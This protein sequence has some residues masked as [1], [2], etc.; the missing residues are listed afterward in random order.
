MVRKSDVPDAA[1][2]AALELAATVGWR[3]LSMRDIAE[4]SGVTLAQLHGVYPTK[5]AILK[6]FSARIDAAVL[7]GDSVDLAAESAK[8]RLFDA[9]MRRFDA[10]SAHKKAACSI[11]RALM[12]RPSSAL[13]GFC[14]TRTS[15]H[16]ML[17]V[18][19]ID[20]GGVAGALRTKGLTLVWLDV[21]RIW[22]A[23]DS[24]DMARTMAHLDRRL[25]MVER[26]LQL[27]HRTGSPEPEA[28]EASP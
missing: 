22:Q 20:T 3:D 8:D 19:G 16:W 25:A 1:L 24:E 23:D 17:E 9:M 11:A 14:L 12:E 2:D 27:L 26:L 13:M 5:T 10:L 4:T 15:M 28:S 18:A 6:A 7:A 21:F